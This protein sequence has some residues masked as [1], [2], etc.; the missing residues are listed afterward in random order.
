MPVKLFC[1]FWLI[2]A[3][4]L[5][6]VI[7][8]RDLNLLLSAFIGVSLVSYAV[9]KLDGGAWGGFQRSIV[10]HRWALTACVGSYATTLMVTS[11]VA[12]DWA[13]HDRVP[14]TCIVFAT[15]AFHIHHWAKG[16]AILAWHGDLLDLLHA[17]PTES[18]QRGITVFANRSFYLAAS[19]IALCIGLRSVN[20]GTSSLHIDLLAYSSHLVM[21]GIACRTSTSNNTWFRTYLGISLGITAAIFASGCIEIFRDFVAG[22]RIPQTLIFW[23][24]GGD[25]GCM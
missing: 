11:M 4:I 14:A 23:Y 5:W 21:L 15:G 7:G 3:A 8:G 2:V 25:V 12:G 20:L 6:T 1:V 18:R 17:E 19:M 10:K 22:G 16:L 9:R 24:P 13:P